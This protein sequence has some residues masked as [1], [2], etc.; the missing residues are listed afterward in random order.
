MSDTGN[1]IIVATLRPESFS[2]IDA[3]TARKTQEDEPALMKRRH[4][5]RTNQEGKAGRS[6]IKS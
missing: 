2:W 5:N 3:A 1:Q 6:G 4:P